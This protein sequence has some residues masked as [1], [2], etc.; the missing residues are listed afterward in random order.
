MGAGASQ[1][2]RRTSGARKLNGTASAN[3]DHCSLNYVAENA[4][5]GDHLMA[6]GALIS[7]TYQCAS[8]KGR[9][10]TPMKLT[11]WSIRAHVVRKLNRGEREPEAKASSFNGVA[12][13]LS[14]TT[15]FFA[16]TARVRGLQ[17]LR[18]QFVELRRVV[19][20]ILLK[21]E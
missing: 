12:V 21:S 5:K 20:R 10:A 15:G 2:T 13:L 6:D 9:K 7:T 14:V 8:G 17:E 4:R 19:S 3:S 18:F 1:R 11:S 16:V